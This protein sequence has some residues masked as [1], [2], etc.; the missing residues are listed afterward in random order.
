M[1]KGPQLARW[2]LT[3]PESNQLIEWTRWHK[4]SQ[5]LRSR[6]IFTCAQGASNRQAAAHCRVTPQ[7]VGKWRSRFVG[8]RLDGELGEPRPGV[9]RKHDDAA[10]EPLIA[11]T[12]TEERPRAATRGH[13]PASEEAAHLAEHHEL[14]LACDWLA[15]VPVPRPSSSPPIRYSSTRSETSCGPVP[16]PADDS[17]SA[18]RGR[19][20]PDPG[21]GTV[22]S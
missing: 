15:A 3:V 2:V 11:A 14:S 17:N 5:A 4:T 18:R 10:I 20:A 12:L 8:R 16:K 19:E 1:R 13:A 9:P 21:L 6:I 22:P 7:P